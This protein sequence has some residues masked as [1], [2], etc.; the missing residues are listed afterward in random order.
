MKDKYI[1]VDKANGEKTEVSK[2]WALSMAG[3]I[4]KYPDRA[5][6]G[7]TPLHPINTAF[8]YIYKESSEA[9]K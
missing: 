8:S 6:N 9:K 4:Y 2:E 3:T 1:R 5:L 7:S